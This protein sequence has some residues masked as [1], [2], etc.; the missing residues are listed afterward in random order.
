[1]DE[2]RYK[3]LMRVA[4]VLT[5][6]W[7]AWTLYD[8]TPEKG[9]GDVPYLAANKYFED[10]DFAAAL[11]EYEEALR[12]HPDHLHAM[13]GKARALLK[14]QR[15]DEALQVADQAI[16]R[17]PDFAATYANRGIIHD[18]LGEYEAA[19]KDYETALRLDPKLAEGPGWMTRFLRN[20]AEPPP[21]VADRARYLRAEL[22]KPE[23][24]RLLR[25]PERD[26]AQRPFKL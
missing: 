11:D 21:T 1:M 5:L 12:Q 15:L 4:I 26:S 13:R 3:L 18:F 17:A 23:D 16:A 9:A 22:A 24:E 14:L 6:A 19:I 10:G 20:Q 7:V 8:T 25:M 2:G